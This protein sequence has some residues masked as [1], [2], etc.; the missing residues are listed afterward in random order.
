MKKLALVCC[1]ILSASPLLRAQ[2]VND[3][4]TN[5][6]SNVTTNITGDVTVGTNGSFTLLTLSDN[7]LL[8][9]SANGVIGLNATARSNEVRLVSASARWRMGGSLFVGS[10]GVANRLVVSNGAFVDNNAGNLGNRVDSSNN[11]ALVTG[12]GSMWS[13]RLDLRVGTGGS[14]NQLLVSNGGWVVSRS[15]FVGNNVTSSNNFALVTGSGSV[16]SNALNLTVGFSGVNNRLVI[17]AGG[18]AH[19]DIGKVGDFG[20]ATDNEALVTGSGSRWNVQTDLTI[21]RLLGGNRLIVSNGAAVW[22]GNGLIGNISTALNNQVLVTGAGS[23][24]SNQNDL[25]VGD[26]GPGNRLVVTNGGTVSASNLFIGFTSFSTNNRVTVDGGTLRVTNATGTGVLD[27]RRGTNVLNTGLIEADRLLV[28]NTSGRFVFNGGTL[29]VGKITIANS[30]DMGDGVTP[31]TLNLTGD[32]THSFPSTLAV[33]SSATLR[34]NGTILVT[35]FVQLGGTLSP[36]TGPGAIGRL[37][38]SGSASLGGTSIMEIGKTGSV[39]TNDQLQVAGTLTYLR[40]LTVS[41]LGPDPL[42]AGDRFQLFP[43][44]S[45]AGSFVILTLPP[46]NPGLVWTNNLLVDGSI[47]VAGLIVQTLPAGKPTQT[48]ATL[49]GLA[50][51]GGVSASGWFEWGFTTNYGNFTPPQALGSGSGNTNFSEVLTGLTAGVTYHFRAV[52]SNTFGIVFGSDQTFPDVI[53]SAYLKA[54]NTGAVDIFNVVAVSGDT[55]VVGATG[56]D[57]TTSGVNGDQS[58]NGTVN[59]GA[60]YVFVRNGNSWVQQAYLKASNPGSSDVFG[61][62]VAIAGDTIV[63]GAPQEDSNA[64]GVNGDGSNNLSFTSGA[65]Y[66]FVRSGTNWSQQAYLKASNTGAGD[67]FGASVAVSGETIV[68]GAESEDSNATGINGDQTNNSGTNSGAAYVFVRSG[69]NWSQQA[70]LKASNTGA[71][72]IFGASVAV[73][74]ETIVVGAESED[75]NATGINGDQANNSGTNCGAAYVFVRNGTNWTQQAYL[76]ASNTE[77]FDQFGESVAISGDTIVVG[78]HGEDSNATGVNG[79]QTNNTAGVSGAAYAFVRSGTNWSQQAYLKASNTEEFDQFGGSV[80]I[81]GEQVVVGAFGE[82]SNATGVNGD[83]D[84]NSATSAGAAYVFV[85]NG[86]NW[87]QRAYLKASNANGGNQ[88]NDFGDQFGGAVALSGNTVVV[89]A[90]GEDSNAIGVDGNQNDNSASLAG[91]AYIFEP[92]LLLAPVLTI[93][94]NG[95]NQVTL[96]W[97]PP[98]SGFVLQE[99]LTLAPLSWSN[100]PSGQ[101]NPITLPAIE[102]SRFFRLF[103]P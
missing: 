97:T 23:V 70:Y 54:S 63:V 33:R 26:F 64:T 46:L 65:A 6:L 42:T 15:G 72:D 2:V 44:G 32:D 93:L 80:A 8:T 43:A 81:S 95:P 102:E 71:G 53:Q 73:S 74:G 96:S 61:A 18:V 60:V 100:S 34:G 68:V 14:G 36:G 16:W 39:L 19:C 3:G 49:K 27:V 89:G 45:Y 22:S 103:K 4:T 56:E 25:M 52:A 69:T 48:S 57:S 35:V 91:A 94:G 38:S 77:E 84:N 13:N 30:F 1:A 55:V 17:E 9:N 98:T 11:F 99:S 67:I 47:E 51:P 79:N 86:T 24:W 40:A 75:S 7:A 90:A 58:N 76:K 41:H 10:N 59:S 83:Q 28:T 88:I 87:S 5:T 21:G 85:R 82:S 12:G 50:N 29:A 31:A 78:A 20:S 37:T 62:S 101:T 66:V 92:P